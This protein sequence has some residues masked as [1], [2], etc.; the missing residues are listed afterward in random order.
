MPTSARVMTASNQPLSSRVT[1]VSAS[2]LFTLC[3]AHSDSLSFPTRRSSDLD[4]ASGHF[5][6]NGV[7]VPQTSSSFEITAAQL[8]NLTYKAGTVADELWVRA[9]DGTSWSAWKT[10][11]ETPPVNHAPVVTASS[12]TLASGVTSVAASSLF[13]VSDADN[14]S[15]VAYRFWDGTTDAAS[16]HFEL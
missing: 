15:I 14:D 4:A 1:S 3:D 5:E 9:F 13:T 11:I 8:A 16:G 2:S 10:F 12:Q 7:V 6:L